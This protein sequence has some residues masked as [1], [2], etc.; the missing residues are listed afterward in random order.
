MPARSVLMPARAVA[1]C[2]LAAALLP[3]QAS[4]PDAWNAHYREVVERCLHESGLRQARALSAPAEF[5]DRVGYA[6]LLI[7]GYLP[8][9]HLKAQRVQMLCLFDK[10]SHEVYLSELL[11]QPNRRP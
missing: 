8:Q 5:D 7:A 2:L 11:P 1:V 6:A 3:A 4:S 10:L 9:A